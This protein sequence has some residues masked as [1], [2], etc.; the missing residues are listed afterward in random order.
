MKKS[1]F[2]PTTGITL[3]MVL[4]AVLSVTHICPAES[5]DDTECSDT[6]TFEIKKVIIAASG[7]A[8]LLGIYWFHIDIVKLCTAKATSSPLPKNEIPPSDS[9]IPNDGP[10]DICNSRGVLTKEDAEEERRKCIQSGT[11]PPS[12]LDPNY[13]PPH[14]LNVV[15]T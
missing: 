12:I 2:R 8:A 3:S 13:K 11:K 4:L 7:I 5:S 1:T 9:Q 10:I 6:K 14:P 15:V